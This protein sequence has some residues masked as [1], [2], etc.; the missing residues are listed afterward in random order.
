M[1]RGQVVRLGFIDSPQGVGYGG[2]NVNSNDILASVEYPNTSTGAPSTSYEEVYTVN[3]LG[4][5]LTYTHHGVPENPHPAG[6]RHPLPDDRG[7]TVKTQV[8]K[9]P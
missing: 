6:R 9:R 1:K 2:S 8:T 4:D 5:N 3:A 7:A